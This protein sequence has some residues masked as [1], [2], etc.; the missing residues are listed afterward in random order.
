MGSFAYGVLVELLLPGG[1]VDLLVVWFVS[2][3]FGMFWAIVLP[4][5]ISL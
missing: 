5:K 4:A 3:C 2:C 1:L